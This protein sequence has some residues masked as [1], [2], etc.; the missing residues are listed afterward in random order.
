M[1]TRTYVTDRAGGLR[2]YKEVS[3]RIGAVLLCVAIAACGG[4]SKK[5]ATTPGKGGAGGSAGGKD[6]QSM[7]DT[8]TPAGGGTSGGTGGGTGGGGGGD[9]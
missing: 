1:I 5:G 7:A 3:R 2:V 6:A 8:G 9:E 4:G